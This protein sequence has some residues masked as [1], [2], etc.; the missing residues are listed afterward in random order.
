MNNIS[1]I[2][3]IDKPNGL[4]S[5][6]VCDK[7]K[8]R[9]KLKKAGHSGTLDPQATGLLVVGIN[10]GTK[11][12]RFLP[13]KNKVYE[14]EIEWGLETDSWDLEGNVL[15]R[16]NCEPKLEDIKNRFSEFIGTISLAIPYFSA[17][18]VDG[19]RLY[20]LARKKVYKTIYKDMEIK[21]IK[22]IDRKKIEITCSIGTYVRSIVHTL[23][24]KLDC[25][26]TLSSLCRTVNNGFFNKDAI[27]LEN[28]LKKNELSDIIISLNDALSHLSP[29][30]ID[31]SIYNGICFGETINMKL[32]KDVGKYRLIYNGKLAAIAKVGDDVKIVNF[33]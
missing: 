4:T 9:F 26:A 22:Y 29:I 6:D 31:K 21:S 20:K 7:I 12:L 10:K 8:K 17:K 5:F 23:G 13:S 11:I 1:G 27:S 16:V 3:L 19:E 24:E 28:V 18:K 30:Y 32:F 2:L 15:K 14:L 25:P 33:T